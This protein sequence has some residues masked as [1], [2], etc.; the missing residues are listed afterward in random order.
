MK[1]NKKSINYQFED[2]T[3]CHMEQLFRLAYART[4]NRQDAED[5]LQETYLKA[6]R[7]FAGL[8]QRGRIKSW[9]THILINTAADQRRKSL[10]SVPTVAISD[11]DESTLLIPSQASPEEEITADEIDPLLL[12]ALKSIPE[13]FLTPLLLRE[14]HEATYEEIAH[15]LDIPIGTVMS[16]LSRGRSMLKSALLPPS[17]KDSLAPGHSAE[18]KQIRGFGHD[19]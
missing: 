8:R 16:R 19:L 6:F 5:I 14:I 9:L 11:V 10:R 17:D 2:S 3:F 13:K 12:K 4:G 1:Q 15:I 18:E 7:A